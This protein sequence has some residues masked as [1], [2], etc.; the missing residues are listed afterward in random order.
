MD[1]SSIS[2]F[3]QDFSQIPVGVKTPISNVKF[4]AS[5][6]ASSDIKMKQNDLSSL[7]EQISSVRSDLQ[8]HTRNQEDIDIVVSKLTVMLDSCEK[9]AV[10]Y[11]S[12]LKQSV[13][14]KKAGKLD[15][16]ISRLEI[17]VAELNREKNHLMNELERLRSDLRF[18]IQTKEQFEQRIENQEASLSQ[19]S[20]R[21]DSEERARLTLER[22]NQRLK[23]E[24]TKTK[25]EL[26]IEHTLEEDQHL[27]AIEHGNQIREM[28]A[29][30]ETDLH[31]KKL[32]I[33]DLQNEVALMKQTESILE[34]ELKGRSSRTIINDESEL[35]NENRKLIEQVTQYRRQCD[36]Y[37]K[38]YDDIYESKLR[39]EESF[40]AELEAFKQLKQQVAPPHQPSELSEKPINYLSENQ[41]LLNN[42]EASKKE[43]AR[44]NSLSTELECRI[45][46]K[47]KRIFGLSDRIQELEKRVLVDSA[48]QRTS[49]DLENEVRILNEQLSDA[50]IRFGATNEQVNILKRKVALIEREKELLEE[51]LRNAR[52]TVYSQGELQTFTGFIQSLKRHVDAE[53]LSLEPMRMTMSDVIRAKEIVDILMKVTEDV[54]LKVLT[55]LGQVEDVIKQRQ[56]AARPVLTSDSVAPETV[57]IDRS[58]N[59]DLNDTELRKRLDFRSVNPNTSTSASARY[60]SE[61]L[62]VVNTSLFSKNFESERRVAPSASM[63]T[64][65]LN[66]SISDYLRPLPSHQSSSAHPVKSTLKVNAP[67]RCSLCHDYGHDS[68]GCTDY[69]SGS[70]SDDIVLNDFRN[71]LKNNRNRRLY[72]ISSR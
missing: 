10:E 24:N 67:V 23:F 12:I 51:Q 20:Q 8:Y 60:L 37:R 39:A 28:K 68:L 59:F 1:F 15:G 35:Q 61:P 62:G 26:D 19:L 49:Q 9:V 44:L 70:E 33:A 29:R 52:V 42:L 36:D 43:I 38:K 72:N 21:L 14:A 50:K 65:S 17:E 7:K 18:E 46:E 55:H 5:T 58:Y 25:T 34:E 3:A 47:E 13:M 69:L 53:I 54:R 66:G 71:N 4:Q 63:V 41:E 57:K 56:P 16:S 30:F 11:E 45:H 27:R 48:L 6:P 31:Q 22:E 32:Q 40:R 2:E 64:T